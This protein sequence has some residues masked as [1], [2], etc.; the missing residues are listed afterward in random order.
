MDERQDNLRDALRAFEAYEAMSNR[1]VAL[2]LWPV[3]ETW[4][5][6][7]LSEDTGIP[8]NTLYRYMK[9]SLLDPDAGISSSSKPTFG[10][11]I[12]ILSAGVGEKRPWMAD[13]QNYMQAHPGTTPEAAAEEL[14]APA[15]S[16]R[17]FEALYSEPCAQE[18][19]PITLSSEARDA[20]RASEVL[21]GTEPAKA[22]LPFER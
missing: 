20:A 3:M 7:R 17:R 10:N 22:H 1:E 8:P 18:E 21:A 13:I 12:K 4:S 11:Y 15:T 19:E 6:N 2:N 16:V 5:M 9:F 14:G